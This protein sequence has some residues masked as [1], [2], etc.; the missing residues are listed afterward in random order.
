MAT[1]KYPM[2]YLHALEFLERGNMAYLYA[3]DNNTIAI[4][5]AMAWLDWE[6]R[7]FIGNAEGF[8]YGEP[9]YRERWRQVEKDNITPAVEV[10]LKVN[11]PQMAKTFF[12]VS[13]MI[14]AHNKQ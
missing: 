12:N 2:D 3:T 1:C 6:Q 4:K 10:M 5:V 14:D 7:Y 13:G 9:I 8:E 11:Q